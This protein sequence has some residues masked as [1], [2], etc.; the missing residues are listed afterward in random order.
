M[1]SSPERATDQILLSPLQGL[2]GF[3]G[4]NQ[5]RR[6]ALPLAILLRPLGALEAGLAELCLFAIAFLVIASLSA[7][8]QT[9][10]VAHPL[11]PLSKE[12]IA[13]AAKLLKE[14]GK[15]PANARFQTIVL[16]EPPK[17][18]VYAFKPGDTFRREA[19]FVAYD[20]ANNKTFDGVADLRK[21]QIVSVREV[22]DAQPSLMLDDVLMFQS[23]VRAD[24][25]WQ[26]AIRKRGI[27]EFGK[28][29]V[30]MWSA[31]NFGFPE[32]Q[33]KRLFRGLSYLREDSKNPYARPIEG[34]IAVVDMNARKVIKV[35]DGGVVPVPR[36]TADVDEKSVGRSREAPKPLQ[37]VQPNGASFEI[38]GNEIRWQKW[39]F[40]YALHPR[41]G[42]VLYTVGYEDQGKVRPILYRAALSEMVVPYGDPNAA[43]FI[44]NAF[45]EGEFA[46]GRL[47]V[48]LEAKNDVPD[49]ATLLDAV[50]ANEGGG[51]LEL[52]RAIALYERDGGVS[53]KHVDYMTNQNQSRR[54]RQLVMGIFVVVGN[55]DYSFNWIFNQDGTIEQEVQLTGVMST[56][57]VPPLN[58]EAPHDPY[59]HV[60]ADGVAAPHHQHFF[61][62]RLDFDV[63]GRANT[64][65][66]QNT[67]TLPVGKDNPYG[68]AF[69][70]HETT[71][72]REVNAQ[73]QLNLATHRRWLVTNP[74]VKNGFGQPTG[75]LLFAGENSIPLPGETS[76]VRKR[77]GFMNSHIWV[78]QFDPSER[79]AAGFYVNQS[80][81]GDGLPKWVKQNRELENKDVVLWYS[82]GVTHLPRPEDYPVM[83]VHKAGFKLMPVG[84]FTQNPA[85]DL[86]KQ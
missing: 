17:A 34:V 81:G 44:R 36:A 33:G 13:A 56:K 8:G 4:V 20:R 25:Q 46:I 60:V 41:E 15:L 85:L 9:A 40:R 76:A 71:L 77:A 24:P 23:I 67:E 11:D 48:S 79:Y 51:S 19:F 30:E 38:H 61:N 6:F 57:G 39:R 16:N 43:W 83:P 65:V 22:P 86:P 59:G 84:F 2:R 29:Q 26:N 27:T 37:I 64:V 45:D 42:L 52:K 58:D 28:V 10:D 68:N 1:Y 14:S 55:Y 78:T 70:M 62:F 69:V 47:A 66:E 63:D 80:K 3:G 53:W 75:Y 21:Q 74:N 31:G 50:L 82:F 12:E 32:E 54:A 35:I 7:Q 73:R 18:E 5:G 49:N 72:R